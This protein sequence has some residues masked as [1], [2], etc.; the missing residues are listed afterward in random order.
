MTQ[1]DFHRY[2]LSVFWIPFLPQWLLIAFSIAPDIPAERLE[3]VSGLMPNLSA[4][5]QSVYAIEKVQPWQVDRKRTLQ[6]MAQFLRAICQISV[7][8]RL[9]LFS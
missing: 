4:C 3:N 9:D 7:P 5:F 2:Q 1:P 8:L 6:D